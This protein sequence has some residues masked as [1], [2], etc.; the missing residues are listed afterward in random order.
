M[1]TD[2]IAQLQSFLMLLLLLTDAANVFTG[3]RGTFGLAAVSGQ[4]GASAAHP[5]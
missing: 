2:A 1:I 5:S 3:S 4:L